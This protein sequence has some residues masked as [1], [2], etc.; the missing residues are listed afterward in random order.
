MSEQH[1]TFPN[2][3]EATLLIALLFVVEMFVASLLLSLDAF[4]NVNPIDLSGLIAVTSNGVLF[5]ALLSYKKMSYGT[6]FH[7]SRQS[8]SGTLAVLALPIVLLVPGL[9]LLAGALNSIVIALAPM[10]PEDEALF[11][12]MVSNDGLAIVF[13]CIAAPLL[14]EMLFRG[15]ILRSFLHQYSRTAAILGSATLFALAHLNVYQLA[16]AFA[17]G[18][19]GGWL[20]ERTRSLWPCILLHAA[21]NAF[22]TYSYALF[23]EQGQ[24]FSGGFYAGA[25]ALAIASGLFL[26]RVLMPARV[27]AR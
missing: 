16:T 24:D 7:A 27:R 3:L 12:A 8:A 6:L 17:L 25:F 19:V 10:A 13:G 20:Y 21:Y 22:V 9:M 15:V 4:A 5:C 18:I 23:A 14:E 2:G 1:E 11:E 26:L